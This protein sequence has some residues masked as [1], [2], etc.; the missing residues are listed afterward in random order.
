MYASCPAIVHPTQLS[1]SIA[2]SS[3]SNLKV[4]EAGE[5]ETLTSAED[6]GKGIGSSKYAARA[7]C[8][9]YTFSRLMV[10]ER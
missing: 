2:C 9:R 10:P 4:L 1:S 8:A 7:N 3:S 5:G 6:A